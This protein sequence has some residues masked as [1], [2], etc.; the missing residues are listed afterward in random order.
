MLTNPRE[1][2][3]AP[4]TDGVSGIRHR[5]ARQTV[6]G[7]L[8]RG[9]PA[10]YTRAMTPAAF[11]RVVVELNATALSESPRSWRAAVNTILT[12]DALFGIIHAY[13]VERGERADRD[14]DYRDEVATA[15][16]EFALLRD[17]AFALKHGKLTHRGA[18]LV[19]HSKALRKDPPATLSGTFILG[20]SF[21]GGSPVMI[22]KDDGTRIAVYILVEAVLVEARARVAGLPT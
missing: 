17:M 3:G 15:C 11:L 13:L 10:R 16:R 20:R 12:T 7:D 22:R 9:A 5:A 8:S 2:L 19:R 4:H 6:G 18:R 21:L 14:T 1:T